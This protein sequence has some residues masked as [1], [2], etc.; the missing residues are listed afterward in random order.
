MDLRCRRSGFDGV[1]WPDMS[2]VRL[3]RHAVKRRY[4][5]SK[6]WRHKHTRPELAVV[7][8]VILGDLSEKSKSRR[9]F[10]H[11]KCSVSLKYRGMSFLRGDLVK[12]QSCRWSTR[13]HSIYHSCYPCYVPII[14]QQDAQAEIT[15]T[16]G[17][18]RTPGPAFSGG[19]R[20]QQ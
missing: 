9:F 4:I 20:A 10:G 13:M 5:R 14:E 18:P 8:R 19:R 17:P 7:R 2:C 12:N 15:V 3:A 16:I 6:H 1:R 11:S